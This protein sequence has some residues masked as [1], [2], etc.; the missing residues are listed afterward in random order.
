MADRPLR[1]RW[2]QDILRSESSPIRFEDLCVEVFSD[3]EGIHYV[4]TSRSYD[5]GRDGRDASPRSGAVSPMI[6]CSLRDD[7][8]SKSKE[9]LERIM[10]SSS[11]TSILFCSTQPIS[12]DAGRTIENHARS[13]CPSLDTVR[14][15]G[16]EQI[17]QL[18]MRFPRAFLHYYGGELANLREAL[19]GNGGDQEH[20]ELTGMRVA[21]TTQLH[22]DF[23]ARRSDLTRN[24][25]V[26]ALASGDRLT[27]DEIAEAV[28]EKLQLHRIVHEA[29][30]RPSLDSLV[31]GDFL[32][33]DNGTYTL[34][35]NGYRELGERTDAGTKRL[36]EGRASIHKSLLELA[37]IT[38]N[39]LE[40]RRFWNVLQDELARFTFG[41]LARIIP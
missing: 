9:D 25:I 36:L 4:R 11:P 27:I 1:E 29:Y 21:L 33:S 20:L 7:F 35:E 41:L 24:L 10:K 18:V 26:T 14:V 39:E 15:N 16:V 12:E 17:S 23:Q 34:A 3:A 37:G 8:D 5:L 28:S 38:L 31:K 2:V 30:L 13:I 40:A 19:F 32:T 6:C 22:A